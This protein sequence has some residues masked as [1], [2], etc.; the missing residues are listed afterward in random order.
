MVLLCKNF[1]ERMFYTTLFYGV[2]LT[3]RK[4][5]FS[6]TNNKKSICGYNYNKKVIKL[7]IWSEIYSMKMYNEKRP[8]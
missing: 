8:K 1:S 6:Y 3:V 2:E 7:E 4:K 5:I